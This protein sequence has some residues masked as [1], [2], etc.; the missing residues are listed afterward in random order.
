MRLSS[1]HRDEQWCST[2]N[3][4]ARRKHQSLSHIMSAMSSDQHSQR[5][6]HARRQRRPRPSSSH[7]RRSSSAPSLPSSS[8]R[9]ATTPT[10][11][12]TDHDG[13]S[14]RDEF[15]EEQ[16]WQQQD[17]VGA[18]EEDYYNSDPMFREG[19]TVSLNR[20]R[21]RV[22]EL[23]KL[24]RNQDVLAPSFQPI[25]GLQQKRFRTKK[26][27]LDSLKKLRTGGHAEAA[28]GALLLLSSSF[29]SSCYCSKSACSTNPNAC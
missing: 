21:L 20:R 3:R 7:V 24:C 12:S 18:E 26:S 6:G 19:E 25:Q 22:A 10:R 8:P 28:K 5:G 17:D 16:R 11:R 14:S 27:R 2:E 9:G 23:L 4:R 13:E 29:S 15:G 1:Q